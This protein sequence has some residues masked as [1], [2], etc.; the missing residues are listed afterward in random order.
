MF[1]WTPTVLLHLIFHSQP[2][3]SP[4]LFQFQ[5]AIKN[6]K[7]TP[8]S[9]MSSFSVVFDVHSFDDADTISN[10]PCPNKLSSDVLKWKR[11]LPSASS[12]VVQRQRCPHCEHKQSNDV[13]NGFSIEIKFLLFVVTKTKFGPMPRS[14]VHGGI[15]THQK[16][17]LTRSPRP[18]DTPVAN[19]FGSNSLLLN[20]TNPQRN[21][22]LMCVNWGVL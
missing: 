5:A 1:T 3:Y 9:Y 22:T 13:L 12:L 15:R 20:N 19:R 4:I 7:D 21:V 18:L 2:V 10:C 14:V 17:V 16:F 6:G 8:T 11:F